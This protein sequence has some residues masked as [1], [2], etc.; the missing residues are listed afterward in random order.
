MVYVF[1]SPPD[2]RKDLFTKQDIFNVSPKLRGHKGIRRDGGIFSERIYFTESHRSV[3]KKAG[4]PRGPSRSHTRLP[5]GRACSSAGKKRKRALLKSPFQRRRT[6]ATSGLAM[7]ANA[8]T[9][10]S[11]LLPLGNRLLLSSR[12]GG[13]RLRTGSEGEEP[14]AFPLRGWSLSRGFGRPSRHWKRS[15]LKASLAFFVVNS[16]VPCHG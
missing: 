14:S 12:G 5:I 10:P 13:L 7:A 6:L 9:N 4:R 16:P 2:W 15:T 11:Q 3:K 1:C 8:T